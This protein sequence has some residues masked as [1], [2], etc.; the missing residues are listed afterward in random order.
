MARSLRNKENAVAPDDDFPYGRL[1]DDTGSGNGVPVNENVYGDFHQFFE[2]LMD[3]GEKTF[4]EQP[5]SDYNGFQ[6]FEAL[7]NNILGG[8]RK[9]IID[10]SIWN[11]NTTANIT[12]AHGIDNLWTFRHKITVIILADSTAGIV[13]NSSSD[14][15]D[16]GRWS[17][18]P[19]DDPTLILLERDNSGKYDS[20][21]YQSVLQGRGWVFVEWEPEIS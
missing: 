1:K 21:N 20:T 5:D 3:V 18:N 6:F 7:F 17:L 10:L 12:V 14:L 13:A 9:K 11:M 8:T 4:N 16:A 15:L 2:R 19:A